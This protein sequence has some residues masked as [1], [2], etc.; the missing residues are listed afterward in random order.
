M[1]NVFVHLLSLHLGFKFFSDLGSI[2][3]FLQHLEQYGFFS[4]FWAEGCL[5]AHGVSALL[6]R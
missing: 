1:A 2:L 5:T 4:L 3:L 6:L